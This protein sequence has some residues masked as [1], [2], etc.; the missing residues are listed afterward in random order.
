MKIH[1][2]QARELFGQFGIPCPKGILALTPEEAVSAAKEINDYPVV[3]KAQIHSGGRGKAG[4]VKLCKTEE[5]VKEFSAELIGKTLYTHQTG[6]EGKVV[7]RIFVTAGCDIAKEY[8]VSMTV[9]SA[10]ASIVMIA[11]AEGGTEIEELSKNHP[12][13][14][15]QMRIDPT[16]GYKDYNGWEMAEKLGLTGDKAKTFVKIARGMYK[17]FVAKDCSLVEINPL[18]ET[19]DGQLLAIDAKVNF[20]DNALF[21]HPDIVELR[22]FDEEDPKEIQASKFDLN[23]VSLDGS[24]GCMVNGAGLA[25]ATMDIIKTFGGEPAN[26]LDVGGSATTERVKAA[27]EI[28]LSDSNVKAILVN[29]FGG[30]MKCD[31]IAQGI[32]EAAKAMEIRVPV[33]VRL[34]GTNAD[35]GREILGASG[36]SLVPAETFAE[37]A[38]KA[39]ELAR[40]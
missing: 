17:L 7:R 16:I 32:V 29:I 8:Y 12:E 39:V 19:A 25:M 28:L 10:N 21:R 38:Q 9:D 27:F 4:G 23:Y 6:P 5:A 22:D 40:A 31:V 35:K 33:V 3:V 14:I 37:A 11:S 1:E 13:K 18:V 20:D 2:Y 30:I 24:V 15:L 36:L 34:D 26:F